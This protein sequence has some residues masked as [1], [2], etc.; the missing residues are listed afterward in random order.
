MHSKPDRRAAGELEAQ[1][2]GVLWA[3][4]G[5]MGT[6][7]IL[8]RLGGHMAY[9]TVAKVLDRLHAK[10]QV[11]R[12]RTGRSY[13]YTPIG[14]ESNW[15]AAHVKRLL[16]HGGNRSDVLQG[17][18][19]GLNPADTETLAKL[20]KQAQQRPIADKQRRPS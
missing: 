15:V 18:V 17:F 9:T 10:G 11:G 14:A 3:E 7:D 1:I 5:D 2:L 16:G 13:R 4:G 19:E 20:L 6:T 8:E 12:T